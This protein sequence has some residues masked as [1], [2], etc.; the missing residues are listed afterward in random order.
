MPSPGSL[1]RGRVSLPMYNLPEMRPLNAAFWN[2]LRVELA[3]RG[4][5][6]TPEAL[7][8]ERRPVPA[9][10]EADTFFTQ[11]CGYPL[12]TIYRGQATILGAPVYAAEHC[13]GAGH[14]GVFIVHRDSSCRQLADLRRCRFAYNSRH[15]NS[16]MN[17]PR[18]R[19]ADIAGGKP[20]L[21]TVTETHSQP[22]NIEGVARGEADASCVD[23]VTYA[24]FRRHRPQLGDLT[25][26]IAVTPP[27]PSIPFVTASRTPEH[28]KQCLREALFAVARSEQWENARAGLMLRDI[29]PVDPASYQIQL[30]Y[31][32]EA[33]DLGYPE[34]A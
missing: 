18:R 34:L 11:V 33:K 32:Q 8:F 10:I 23:C 22:G 2:A 1:Y 26:V 16:G 31:V 14:A 21:G 29:V 17:L 27:S 3:R 5:G 12:Q 4:L 15:S 13:S 9:E 28:V 20:F 7:D 30:A 24:F 6:D 25:R 19:L